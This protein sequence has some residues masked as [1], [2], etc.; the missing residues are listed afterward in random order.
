M[1]K[2]SLRVV[3]TF[4][5]AF[6]LTAVAM[7][8]ISVYIMRNTVGQF[9]EGSVNLELQQAIRAFETGGA[10]SLAQYLAETDE[11]LKGTRFLT[12]AEGRDL[13]SGEDRSEMKPPGLNFIGMPKK[14]NG[15]FIIVKTSPDRRYHLVVVAPPPLALSRFLP[16]FL[17]LALAIVLLALELSARI[18]SPLRRIAESVNRFGKGDLSARVQCDYRQDEIGVLARSFNSMAGRIETLLTAERRLLQDVSHE[19]RSPLARLSF[20]AELMKDAAHPEVAAKRVRREIERLSQL[21]GSL[22]EM[23]SVEGDPSSRKTR[24]VLIADLVREIV[25]D[26]NIEASV[27]GVRIG[28]EIA[29]PVL[30]EGDPE[31]LRRA[32]E[33]VLRNAIRFA[34]S[35]S[36]ISVQVEADSASVTV[37]VRDFGPGVPED[38][39][40]RIFDPFFRVEESRDTATGCVGLGL[41]I[42]RRAVLLHHGAVT[43][44]NAN[45]GLQ[46]NIT[47]PVT[48]PGTIN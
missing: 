13:V 10:R 38:M 46:V 35:N 42:A 12:D 16:Y 15:Q 11:A 20:A 29:S 23:T 45:P 31:L 34:P 48:G 47:I 9:F 5:I 41:S 30:V 43:A 8:W 22:L 2:L 18:V 28:S 17:L 26:C 6:I 24:S 32:I 21:I 14:T 37:K 40:A 44:E 4:T 33:N 36:G 19:L 27:R 3:V 7:F 25:A 39:L 1:G